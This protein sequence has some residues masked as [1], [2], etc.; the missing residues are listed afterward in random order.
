MLILTLFSVG[1]AGLIR[2]APAPLTDTEVLTAKAHVS[3]RQA[4]FERQKS[5][6]GHIDEPRHVDPPIADQR[7]VLYVISLEPEQ[8]FKS[9]RSGCAPC[10][11]C[12]DDIQAGKLDQ[13]RVVFTQKASA[14]LPIKGYPTLHWNDVSGQGRYQT[15]WDGAEKFL[16]L[17]RSTDAGVGAAHSHPEAWRSSIPQGFGAQV[18]T[19]AESG[20]LELPKMAVN[21]RGQSLDI[22]EAK[23]ARVNRW[24]SVGFKPGKITHAGSKVS[25]GSAP[26]V[27]FHAFQNGAGVVLDSLQSIEFSAGQVHLNCARLGRISFTVP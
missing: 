14:G 16:A 1:C 9:R 12:W 24:F 11:N 8:H 18:S 3:I 2:S 13:F 15:G 20:A 17:V 4:M 25:F 19:V 7:R 23:A 21:V 22:L 26:E 10:Q 5:D 6:I 27:R